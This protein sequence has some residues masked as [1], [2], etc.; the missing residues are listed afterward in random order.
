IPGNLE[1]DEVVAALLEIDALRGG[2]GAKE[3]PNLSAFEKATADGLALG[4]RGATVV[5][6]VL[7]AKASAIEH[8]LEHALRIA[9]FG[10]YDH[11]LVADAPQQVEQR[12][13]LRL[14]AKW[15]LL[16]AGD[17][18]GEYLDLTPAIRKHHLLDKQVVLGNILGCV[19]SFNALDRL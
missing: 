12:L 16:G 10:E 5:A 2:V 18:I 8:L 3:H 7:A 13:D 6:E 19:D 17:Q 1:V 4:R 14:L 11:L 9:K 15:N